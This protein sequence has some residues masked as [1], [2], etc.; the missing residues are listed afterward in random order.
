MGGGKRAVV[1]R[2]VSLAP[3]EKTPRAETV[4]EAL[5]Q[6]LRVGRY[7]IAVA[8]IEAGQVRLFREARDF[9]PADV[10]TALNLLRA[11][12]EPLRQPPAVQR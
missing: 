6:A 3:A 7:L 5:E 8:R 4:P 2:G 1:R 11:N 9:P 10:E 12:C